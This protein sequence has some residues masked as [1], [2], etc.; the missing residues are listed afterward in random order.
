MEDIHNRTN[1][2][3]F[4]FKDKDMET[5][6]VKDDNGPDL[7]FTGELVARV[8]SEKDAPGRAR[9]TELALYKTQSGK[10]VCS[11][12]GHTQLTSEH[13]RYKA[14]VCDSS[15]SVPCIFGHG[16][17]AK[18]LYQEAKIES[19]LDLDTGKMIA[20][21]SD[22]LA[23]RPTR[24]GMSMVTDKDVERIR[25]AYTKA[26]DDEE[27]FINNKT[28][29]TTSFV[30]TKAEF[31][32]FISGPVNQ[33]YQE[34]LDHKLWNGSLEDFAEDCLRIG[35]KPAKEEDI[36]KRPRLDPNGN[37]PSD[38]KTASKLKA[39]KK[40]NTKRWIK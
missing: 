28:L 27:L 4:W 21:P 23:P 31:A 10:Y 39:S 11:E 8:E 20:P 3:R 18:K 1:Q 40:P 29:A 2:R 9:W 7:R 12:I 5:I 16:W 30:G 15:W 32:K 19:I 26:P 34:A 6:I 35:L 36:R 25:N 38:Y 24:F 33:W 14:S 13:T 22:G 37:P 17:L